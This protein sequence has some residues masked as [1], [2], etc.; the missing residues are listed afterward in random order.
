VDSKCLIELAFIVLL[1]T[2]GGNQID[3]PINHDQCIDLCVER[4]ASLL[5]RC[6]SLTT[7]EVVLLDLVQDLGACVSF[8]EL[9]LDLSKHS[10]EANNR[11]LSIYFV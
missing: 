9:V 1:D 7:L 3:R 11:L 6:S 5:V 2:E 4:N 8:R 10:L